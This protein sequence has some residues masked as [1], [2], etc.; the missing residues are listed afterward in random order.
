MRK[1]CWQSIEL[2]GHLIETNLI[3]EMS[4]NS[5]LKITMTE[6]FDRI[7]IEGLNRTRTLDKE[8]SMMNMIFAHSFFLNPDYLTQVEIKISPTFY[9]I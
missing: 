7:M 5:I 9:P 4:K 8:K 3:I 6:V 2:Y 1:N